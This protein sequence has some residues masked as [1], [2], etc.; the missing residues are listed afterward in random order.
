MFD[1]NILICHLT[2]APYSN[3]WNYDLNVAKTKSTIP[4][5]TGTVFTKKSLDWNIPNIVATIIC[6]FSHACYYTHQY[7]YHSVSPVVRSGSNQV[8]V[9][10]SS[11]KENWNEHYLIHG[12]DWSLLIYIYRNILSSYYL[13]L[14]SYCLS[15][16]KSVHTRDWTQKYNVTKFH[17][18]RVLST[19]FWGVGRFTVTPPRVKNI[20][21]ICTIYI[22]PSF[23][24]T[25]FGLFLHLYC[26]RH[27]V[28]A[29]V[30]S[31]FFR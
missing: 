7:F 12:V 26:H 20:G 24:F 1:L 25:F 10:P 15:C 13:V 31:T 28:S 23:Y 3:Q 8:I 9:D 27:E 18:P 19:R 16:F 22:F 4:S 2:S 11:L 6:F 21:A 29:V 5:A 14:I 30:R 17:N